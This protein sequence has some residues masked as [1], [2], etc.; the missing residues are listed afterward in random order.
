MDLAVIGSRRSMALK[1]Q[2]CGD[3]SHSVRRECQLQNDRAIHLPGQFER[4]Q[5][6][7]SAA[8]RNRTC[9]NLSAYDL[10]RSLSV[11]LNPRRVADQLARRERIERTRTPRRTKAKHVWCARLVG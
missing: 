9:P 7:G 8:R 4:Y 2:H 10:E 6:Q 5:A 1:D 3:L 11:A